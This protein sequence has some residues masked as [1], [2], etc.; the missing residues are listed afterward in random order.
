MN[1]TSEHY[2]D[3]QVLLVIHYSGVQVLLVILFSGMHV[4]PLAIH[5]SDVHM[6]P[7]YYSGVHVLPIVITYFCVNLM[8]TN[9]MSS[10][11]K[12]LCVDARVG[13]LRRGSK[14]RVRVESVFC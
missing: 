6:L 5:Y 8:Q 7:Q 3:V 10:L 11:F 9:D 12:V 14:T 1:V 13:N 4:L 2:S